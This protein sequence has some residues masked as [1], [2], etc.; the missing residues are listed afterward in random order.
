[1]VPTGAD[2]I[3]ISFMTA[4]VLP[5]RKQAWLQFTLTEAV[6]SHYIWYSEGNQ[7]TSNQLKCL[8]NYWSV[9]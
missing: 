7:H 4:A 6:W 2:K 5:Q 1:M 3:L 9:P 8:Q